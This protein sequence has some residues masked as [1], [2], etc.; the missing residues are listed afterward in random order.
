MPMKQ[1]Y[2]SFGKKKA[3]KKKKKTPKKPMKTKGKGYM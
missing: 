3:E 1:G 2:G